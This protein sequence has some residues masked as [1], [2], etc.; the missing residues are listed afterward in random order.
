MPV[1]VIHIH[2]T[3]DQK[4]PIAS[5][6]RPPPPAMTEASTPLGSVPIEVLAD[7]KRL[8]QRNRCENV[9]V[10]NAML[11]ELIRLQP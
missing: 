6:V 8:T 3:D 11:P 2:G 10:C 5:A 4:V 9:T 1:S 7:K